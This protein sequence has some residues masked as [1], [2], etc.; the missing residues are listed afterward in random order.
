M[1]AQMPTPAEEAR[2]LEIAEK[3]AALLTELDTIDPGR[4]A[5]NA[6]R[7]TGPG[8]EIRKGSGG[9]SARAA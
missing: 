4:T 5:A 9:W 3:V 2:A 8:V 1:R 6:G 7:I